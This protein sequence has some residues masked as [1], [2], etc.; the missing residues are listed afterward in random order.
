MD[1]FDHKLP[2]EKT[3]VNAATGRVESVDTVNF[4]IMPPPSDKCQVCAID[5]EP[6]LMHDCQSLFYQYAFYGRHGRWPTWTDASCHCETHII[7][8]L[9]KVVASHDWK[10][11]EPPAGENPIAHLGEAPAATHKDG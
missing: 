1:S 2:V 11:T 6:E 5:H 9:K 4:G 8:A 10:W 3:T 7:E